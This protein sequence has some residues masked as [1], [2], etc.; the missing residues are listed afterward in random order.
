MPFRWG[1]SE[2]QK[3]SLFPGQRL[4]SPGSANETSSILVESVTRSSTETCYSAIPKSTSDASKVVSRGAGL[5]KAF[6]GQKSSFS[7]DCSK[8][9]TSTGTGWMPG[10]FSRIFFALN[11]IAKLE[12]RAWGDDLVLK[13]NSKRYKVLTKSVLIQRL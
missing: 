1:E 8:A 3:S 10:W 13:K 11:Q 2:C 7:V 4:V 9:G 6:V 5:S 12:F